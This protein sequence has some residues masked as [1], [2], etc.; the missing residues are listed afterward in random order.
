MNQND[1]WEKLGSILCF[2]L[3]TKTMNQND[4]RKTWAAFCAYLKLRL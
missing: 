4:T 2:Y 3:K 1:T